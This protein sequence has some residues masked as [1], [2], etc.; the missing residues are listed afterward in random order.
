M[1]QEI[2]NLLSPYMLGNLQL[3]NRIVMAPMTR[4]RAIGN[5][6]NELMAT[7]YGQ[8]AEAGLIITEGVSP[9]PNGLGYA[10]IPGLYNQEQADGWKATTDAVHNK[11]GKIFIQLMHSGRIGHNANLP[12]GA[13]LVAPS[14]ITAK[15]DMW[16]DTQGMQ[17]ISAPKEIAEADIKSLIEEYVNS[18]RLAVAAGFDGVELHAANGYLP[19]QFLSPS[20]NHRS[21]KYGGNAENRNR[22]VV[23]LA[24]A[25][26]GAIGE[27]KTGIRLSPFN[28]FNDIT[29]DEHEAAQYLTL[30][31]A[32][33]N[34]GLTYVHFL[35]FTMKP[36]FI[37]EM[38]NA[39]GGVIMLNGGYTGERAAGDI[40]GGKC[41]LVSF[42]SMYVSNP[43]LVKR[44]ATGAG[45]T[46]PDQSTFYTAD[47]KGYTDYP[48]L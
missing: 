32:L 23:E 1:T 29:P 39:F 15:G 35:T 17:P 5:Q 42:G 45:L 47:A 43:D 9:S 25:V 10:R 6:P 4:C 18:A 34:T 46:P 21:D 20:T 13:H 48:T 12:E 11:G 16:T 22:F 2:T 44:I 19:M 41:D 30:A 14:A 24:E 33:K 31:A 36:E 26:A 38:K 7:Y 27:E 37:A 8:R 3:K 40:A 28:P